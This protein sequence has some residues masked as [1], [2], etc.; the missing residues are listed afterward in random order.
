MVEYY[1]IALIALLAAVSPGPDFVIVAKNALLYDRRSG[2]MTS[3]GAGVLVHSFYCV[4][5]LAVVISQSLLLFSL[6]KYLGAA[7]LIYLG[8]KSLFSEKKYTVCRRK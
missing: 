4:L 2:V 7:Y 6:I 5:G 8:V 1:T 3:V